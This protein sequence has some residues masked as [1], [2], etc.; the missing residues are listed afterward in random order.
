MSKS[1][2]GGLVARRLCLAILAG[3]ALVVPA[4]TASATPIITGLHK[5]GTEYPVGTPGG[6]DSF[7]EVYALP[8]A[9][10]GPITAGYQ[11]WVF[12]GGAPQGNVPRQ[13]YP[14]VGNGGSDNVGTNGARGLACSR[15]RQCALR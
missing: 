8:T 6:Q 15:Q 13:W 7:W 11:A 9:Y 10:T 14:G 2:F 3:L 5:T 12:T 4:A 1:V